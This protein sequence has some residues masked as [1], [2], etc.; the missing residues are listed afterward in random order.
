MG[1]LTD[2]LA[3]K[4]PF[5]FE[6]AEKQSEGSF[7]NALL[8]ELCFH[9][10]N[11]ELYRKFC[12]NK[13]FAP[14]GFKGE[15]A[16]IPPVQVSVFKELGASLNSVPR[17]NIKLTLQSSATSGIPSSIPVDAITAKRQARSMIKVVGDYIGNERKPFLVMDVDPMAGFREIL[18]ARYAAVSGYLNFASEVGYFLKVND[19]RQYYFDIKGIKEFI[20]TL[21]GQSAVVF[22]FTYILYSEVIRPLTEQGISFQLPPG[23]KVIHIGGWK[24]LESEKISKSEFN[25]LAAKLFGVD[26]K[27]II[28]IYGFTEQMG[29]NYPDCPCGCKHAPLYSE[30]I[31]RDVITKEVLSQGDEGLLEFVTPIPHSYPGNVVL[32]DDIGVLVDGSCKYGRDGTRFKVIGRLKKA[33]IRGCGDILSSKLK[34]TGQNNANTNNDSDQPKFHMFYDGQRQFAEKTAT[35]AIKNVETRL[36][37][38]L[39]WLREQ[40]VDAL[41]GLIAVVADKWLEQMHSLEQN[42][43]QGMQFLVSWCSPDNLMRIANDGLRGNRLYSDGFVSL[44]DNG[45]RLL[46][47]TSRGLVCHWLAGNVQV[48]GMFVL[49]QSILAKNV[50]LLRVSSRDKGSFESLV[51]AFKGTKFVT[52]GGYEVCGDDILK[53]IAVVFF[54]HSDPKANKQMSVMADARIAWGG[55]EAVGTVAA[56]PSKYDCEDIIMGPKISFSVV[57][58]EA[59]LDERKARKLARKIAVDASVFDQTGCASAHNVFVEKGDNVSPEE[60]A[61]YLAVGMDKVSKQIKKG[62]MTAEEFVAVHSARGIYDFKGKVFGDNESV[63]TVLYDDE[64]ALNKPVYSRVVF[65]HAVDKISDVLEYVSED[66]QTIGLAANGDK[67]LEFANK[68]VQRGAIRFPL[69]GKMLNFES[70]WDGMFIIDRLVKWNTLGGPMA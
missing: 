13:R 63:W 23:S 39:A 16:D 30:V 43:Q 58:K 6:E 34:F 36:R 51:S 26:E 15:L 17:G 9:Y 37:N 70:P 19:N 12:D 22:G 31:V 45:I 8:E 64:P 49:I 57:A 68:A 14:H 60:F 25:S 62:Q 65:V 69:P 21:Q 11:N 54:D 3:K 5:A 35:E 7:Y 18:G 40:P 44:D 55:A 50:N 42:Q 56:L 41:I 2:E 27:D 20:N 1:F 61:S 59:I 53:T 10:D 47:A 67:A 29:L 28:D 4:A 66:T 46:R 33:E 52:R 24:K 38:Q 48:L 32:T